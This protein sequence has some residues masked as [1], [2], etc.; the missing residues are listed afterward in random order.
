MKIIEWTVPEFEY[1]GEKFRWR[2]SFQE[3]IYRPAALDV[4][5]DKNY[6]VGRLVYYSFNDQWQFFYKN[7]ENVQELADMLSDFVILAYG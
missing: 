2:I 6:F 5:D 7:K 4:Y 3:T 1:Q